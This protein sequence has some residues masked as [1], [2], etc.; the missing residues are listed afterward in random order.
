MH[1]LKVIE[2]PLYYHLTW[3][4]QVNNTFLLITIMFL[5]LIKI[6]EIVGLYNMYIVINEKLFFR[7]F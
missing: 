5:F 7:H 4:I 6:L 2:M 3:H 1:K